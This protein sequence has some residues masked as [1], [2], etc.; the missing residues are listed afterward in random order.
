MWDVI[1]FFL[2]NVFL[3][4]LMRKA[5]SHRSAHHCWQLNPSHSPRTLLGLGRCIALWGEDGA[6]SRDKNG[7]LNYKIKC[8]LDEI[9]NLPTC[10]LSVKP[11]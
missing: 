4:G 1:Q 5:I 8:E 6:R 7:K 3:V 2:F 9:R 10:E 11:G